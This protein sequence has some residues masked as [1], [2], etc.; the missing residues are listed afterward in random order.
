MNTF[1][2]IVL[3]TYCIFITSYSIKCQQFEGRIVSAENNKPLPYA[4][5]TIENSARG[6]IA[7]SN[8]QYKLNVRQSDTNIIVSYVGFSSKTVSTSALSKM[9]D[10]ELIPLEVHLNQV[11][12]LGNNEFYFDL[13]SRLKSK[14]I[15]SEIVD[16]KAYLKIQSDNQDNPIELIEC[17]YNT[18]SNNTGINQLNLKNGRAG[19][20]KQRGKIFL[21]F[22]TSKLFEEFNLV[23][24]NSYVPFNPFQLRRKELIKYY[25]VQIISLTS[26]S[27][28]HLIFNPKNNFGNFFNT[29][30]WV[31]LVSEQLLKIKLSIENASQ[32]PI[33]PIWENDNIE[34]LSMNILYEF[35][36][37]NEKYRLNYIHYSIGF[38]YIH[39]KLEKDQLSAPSY[40]TKIRTS[41]LV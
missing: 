19:I 17:Y 1:R 35:I 22:N 16:S 23:E 33:I 6:T 28:V 36:N 4:T 38:T 27:I 24:K 15:G 31:D 14:L 34:N 7:N 11:T 29:E 40:S 9:S 21:N 2:L 37:Q 41:G 8:G 12:I 10:I 20:F 3:F 25:E 13:I 26:D 5:L 39:E 32:S 30:M 18:K